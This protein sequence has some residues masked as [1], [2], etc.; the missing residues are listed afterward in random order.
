VSLEK[1]FFV[2]FADSRFKRAAVRIK[3]QAK[4]MGKYDEIIVADE[5]S[6]DEDFREK[7]K[8]KLNSDLRG[9]GYWIWKP[10]ILLQ[11][12]KTL[13]NG[14]LVQYTDAGCHLN[15]KGIKR[16]DEYFSIVKKS[17]SG[18]LAFDFRPPVFDKTAFKRPTPEYA[19]TKG[20][21]FDYF[22]VRCNKR[23]TQ[24]KQISATTFFL[25]KSKKTENLL[26]EWLGV[27]ES[28]FALVD[29][30]PSKSFNFKGF[31][32]N[33]HDQSIFSIL[34]K[35]NNAEILSSF[36]HWYLSKRN[37]NVLD[38]EVLKDYPIW[39]EHDLGVMNIKSIK[40]AFFS[41]WLYDAYLRLKDI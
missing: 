27:Y 8:D 2:S 34:C 40:K 28:N 21:L 20:D 19:W 6:L 18:I 31:I 29:D 12:F 33:R 13:R 38:H 5:F 7:F 9:F 4:L 11:V 16:L 30:T 32:E 17:K 37:G 1:N 39:A 25:K 22:R 35:M 26:K 24:S 36:E 3:K 41:S 14:D 15:N 10:K 23:I